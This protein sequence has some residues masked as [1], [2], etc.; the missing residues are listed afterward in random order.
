MLGV[1]ALGLRLILEVELDSGHHADVLLEFASVA[2][3]LANVDDDDPA[4]CRAAD[5]PDFGAS[6]LGELIAGD[7]GVACGFAQHLLNAMTRNASWAS[8]AGAFADLL[9]F[10]PCPTSQSDW[11]VS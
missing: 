9:N 1:V 8:R 6:V 4:L 10:T 2:T 5:S 3:V 11:R 7:M